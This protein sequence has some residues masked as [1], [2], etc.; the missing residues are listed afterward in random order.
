[1]ITYDV[2]HYEV[3]WNSRPCSRQR[4]ESSIFP[5]ISSQVL[6]RSFSIS[7][8]V[9]KLGRPL[10]G[11]ITRSDRRAC[12]LAEDITCYNVVGATVQVYGVTDFVEDICSNHVAA[13]EVIKVNASDVRRRP[14]PRVDVMDEVMFN[15][16]SP[17]GRITSSIDGARVSGF[18]HRVSD[19]VEGDAMVVA[20]ELYAR[21]RRT[22]DQ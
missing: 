1:M 11:C 3:P 20:C 9:S 12:H 19:L 14:F 13:R 17:S 5:G 7:P 16:V 2:I 15:D 22:Y 4:F 21:V 18:G 6:N 10:T 8:Q